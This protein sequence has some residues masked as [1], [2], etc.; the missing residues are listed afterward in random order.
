MLNIFK[1]GLNFIHMAHPRTTKQVFIGFWV[2][3][4]IVEK[5]EKD[6]G[7]VPRSTFLR[8]ALA[9]YLRSKG[10]IIEDEEIAPPDRAGKGG[11]KRK[12]SPSINSIPDF[13]KA[14]SVRSELLN[15]A[16]ERVTNEKVDALK[17]VVP[18]RK[19]LPRSDQ[20][21]DHQIPNTPS[22]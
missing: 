22:S 9:D 5:I 1:L 16:L 11:P 13:V 10:H 14:N 12:S 20:T 18:K 19:V 17:D 8:D 7:T 6:R 3:E 2:N 21:P 15:I 4:S